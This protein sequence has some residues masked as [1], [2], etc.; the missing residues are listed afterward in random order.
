MFSSLS[1]MPAI[2]DRSHSRLIDDLFAFSVASTPCSTQ[3]L[4]PQKHKSRRVALQSVRLVQVHPQPRYQV[5]FRV[6]SR[7]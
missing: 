6:M 5:R 1:S 3:L 7:L 4:A 2:G